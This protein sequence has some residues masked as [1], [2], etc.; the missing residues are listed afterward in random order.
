MSMIRVR[1]RRSVKE[2]KGE[3]SGEEEAG[4]EVDGE[5]GRHGECAEEEKRNVN[6]IRS[7]FVIS[8]WELWW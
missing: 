6:Q 8:C 2:E 7:D 1:R 3:V 4:K 5:G